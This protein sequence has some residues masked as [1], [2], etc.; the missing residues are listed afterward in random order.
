MDIAA[1]AQSAIRSPFS[2]LK[3]FRPLNL[4]IVALT[5]WLVVAAVVWPAFRATGVWWSVG[6]AFLWK[7][8][9]ATVL[10]TASG[11]VVNDIFDHETDRINRPLRQVVGVVLSKKT[12]SGL[13]GWLW[14]S[15]LVLTGLVFLESQPE[16]RRLNLLAFPG[17]AV[18]LFL[19]S[20][21]LKGT[22]FVGNFLVAVFCAAV[23]LLVYFQERRPL[24][25]L[26][27]HR[28][29]RAQLVRGVY[30]ATPPNAGATNFLWYKIMD[31]QDRPGDAATGWKTAPVLLGE[32]FTRWF[33]F[34]AAV[35]LLVFLV[36]CLFEMRPSFEKEWV[37]WSAAGLLV[38]PVLFVLV[39][40]PT[41]SNASAYRRTAT[42]VKVL[43]FVGLALLA[44]LGPAILYAK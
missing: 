16:A 35:V 21:K 41:A 32:K 14:L 4:A 34:L 3:I 7:I 37:F 31:L 19:Y 29:D 5:Q 9:A 24:E 17:V 39:K 12:S 13:Y 2:A 20:W 28:P 25:V 18:G 40:L 15:I 42:A 44:V 23:P 8:V 6:P 30:L 10:V 22:P 11:Y 1:A 43:M 36:K 33:A 38:A 26:E 27:M